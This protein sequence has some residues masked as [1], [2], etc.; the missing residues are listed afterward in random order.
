MKLLDFIVEL[1]HRV[2]SNPNSYLKPGNNGP[3]HDPE[4]PVRNYGHWLITF[5]KCFELTGEQI[6]LKKIKALADYLISNK[7][8]LYGFSFYH[9]FKK[10]KDKCNGLI[11][12]AWTFEA[13]AEASAVIRDMKYAEILKRYFLTTNSI[14]NSACGIV[15]RL[16]ELRYPQ[17]QPLT[18]SC[19][20]PPVH[21]Y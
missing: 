9:R 21:H 13:L 15:W 17:I 1:S 12:Q 7:S 18:I 8:R 20:L 5:S 14:Q 3:Y 10:G 4:T 6:Y 19:G 11:G 16:M 2:L